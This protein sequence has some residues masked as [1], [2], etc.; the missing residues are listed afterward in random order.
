MALQPEEH[1]SDKALE[2]FARKLKENFSRYEEEATAL[3]AAG[4]LHRFVAGVSVRHFLRDGGSGYQI[5]SN[6]T[7]Q[8][9][10]VFFQSLSED[11]GYRLKLLI[12]QIAQSEVDAS[13]FIGT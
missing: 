6:T 2:L 10:E 13:D 12:D 3:L 1:S 11:P 9:E 5:S 8:P 4:S 7:E